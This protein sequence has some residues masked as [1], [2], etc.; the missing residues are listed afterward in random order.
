ME[1]E[2]MDVTE[3]VAENIAEPAVELVEAVGKD[4][5]K[6]GLIAGGVAVAV[7]GV[8]VARKVAPKVSNRIKT[9][10]ANHQEKKQDK[11]DEIIDASYTV[12]NDTDDELD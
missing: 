10:W 4:W 11:R 3:E 9:A 6:Y 7:T 8:C 2:I 12:I 1:N 5:H